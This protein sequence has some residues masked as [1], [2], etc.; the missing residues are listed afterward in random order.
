MKFGLR[1]TTTFFLAFPL[2]RSPSFPIKKDHIVSSVVI[3]FG[4]ALFSLNSN[5]AFLLYV[6]ENASFLSVPLRSLNISNYIL[7]LSPSCIEEDVLGFWLG[8]MPI[9]FAVAYV[10]STF[11]SLSEITHG[12]NQV[13]TIQWVLLSM[14]LA[15]SVAVLAFITIIANAP[16][17]LAKLDLPKPVKVRIDPLREDLERKM[18]VTV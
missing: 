8:M 12:S 18:L 6:A 3:L 13:S 16:D 5:A 2:Q 10:G 4:G 14:G 9:A 1:I 11:K 17:E 7:S 15:L